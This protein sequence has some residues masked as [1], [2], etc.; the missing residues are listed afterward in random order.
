MYGGNSNWRGP[1]WFPVNYLVIRALLQYDQFFGPGLHH[2][3]PDRIRAA[4]EPARRSPATSPT[5]WSASGCPGRTGADRCTAGSSGCRPTRPGG[6]PAVLRVLPRRQRRRPR[7]HAPDRVDRAGRRPAHRPTP[8]RPAAD[9]RHDG[10]QTRPR[11]DGRGPEADD[12][13]RSPARLDG[14]TPPRSS[15]R[16]TPGRG[17]RD[18]RREGRPSTSGPSRTGTGT[19]WPTLRLRRGLADGRLAAQPRRRRHRP[20]E[21]R[22]RGRLP[23]ALPDWR[24]A[25]VVGSP[26]LHPRLRRRRPPGRSGRPGRRPAGAG[27][28]RDAA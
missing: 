13:K 12:R 18:Q 7:R 26:V 3:V 17:W 8:A 24:A 23:G 27:R 15:T 25:D 19:S 14:S 5:G 10:P 9:L 2:R 4:A 6:Q 21:P 28:P 20:G 1:V 11:P 22:P 16:S